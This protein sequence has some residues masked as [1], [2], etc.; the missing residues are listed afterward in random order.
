VTPDEGAENVWEAELLVH[1]GGWPAAFD[2]LR[3]RVRRQFN[4]EE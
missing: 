4:L 2:L 3:A 1:A